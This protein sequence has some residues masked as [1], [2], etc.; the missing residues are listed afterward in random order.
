[1]KDAKR[2]LKNFIGNIRGF[3]AC[4]NCGDSFYWKEY[5]SVFYDTRPT[6]PGKFR[7]RTVEFCKECLSNKEK[8][9]EQEISSYLTDK[10]GWTKGKIRLVTGTVSAMKQRAAARQ[11]CND[12]SI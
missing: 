10:E 7:K 8:L 12:K 3:P 1:M 4:P 9:D 11:E 2:K 5:G 6:V